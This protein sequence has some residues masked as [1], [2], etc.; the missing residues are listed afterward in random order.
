M[1]A[2]V[3]PGCIF[4]WSSQMIYEGNY[5]GFSFGTDTYVRNKESF[6]NIDATPATKAI[7]NIDTARCSIS[8]QSKVCASAF[9]KIEKPD[10]L[11]T[12]G[13]IGDYT[14]MNKGIGADFTL[15]LKINV[16]F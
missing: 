13:L 14:F 6:S 8:Y 12:V 9:W 5:G 7:I 10:K 11:F 15:A 4:R 16:M 2:R 3:H 1:Q